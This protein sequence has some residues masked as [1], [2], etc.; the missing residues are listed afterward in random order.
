MAK[1]DKEQQSLEAARSSIINVKTDLMNQ[2]T[3]LQ[4]QEITING[5]RINI[6]TWVANHRFSTWNY[7]NKISRIEV[8]YTSFGVMGMR[9]LYKDPNKAEET[10]GI[11]SNTSDS[12]PSTIQNVDFTDDE[13]LMQIQISNMLDQTIFQ[14]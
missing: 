1:L 7:S 5:Q 8:H 10:L 9:I 4:K 12:S 14:M 2:K 11:V 3:N 6:E 13:W